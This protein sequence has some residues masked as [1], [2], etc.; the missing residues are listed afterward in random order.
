MKRKIIFSISISLFLTTAIVLILIEKGPQISKSVTDELNSDHN[1]LIKYFPDSNHSLSSLKS[2]TESTTLIKNDL[3]KFRIK[4]IYPTLPGGTE[5][6]VNME[7]PLTDPFF[8][9]EG[10]IIITPQSDGSL[11]ISSEYNDNQI[12]L[13]S[14][15]PSNNKWLNTETT[16]YVK[17]VEYYGPDRT[18]D[19]FQ[20]KSRGGSEHNRDKPCIGSAYI[21][22]FYDL[23]T[24]PQDRAG[25]IGFEKEVTH[26]AYTGVTL[27]D[28]MNLDG[29]L[30]GRWIG[31][32]SIIYNINLNGSTFV[33]L[34]AFIDQTSDRNGKLVISN[35]WKKVGETIDNGWSTSDSEFNPFCPK[36]SINNQDEY[37]K[38]NEI[39]SLPGGDETSNVITLRT[40][41][42]LWNFKYFTV[43]EILAPS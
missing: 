12:R 41:N 25:H 2:S 1:L 31:L 17:I 5:W 27:S 14:R 22:R 3:D 35:N 36:L 34:Q 38:R 30:K 10:L 19:Q 32:K 20:I 21:T 18:N 15:S 43:R 8:L 7:Q 42:A 40:D 16:V 33:K 6:Y 24:T 39:I 26:P 9:K 29:P 23:T 28:N 11:Q 37:R 13:H 4:K